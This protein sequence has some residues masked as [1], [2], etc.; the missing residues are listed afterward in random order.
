MDTNNDNRIIDY[1]ETWNLEAT[2]AIL[3]LLQPSNRKINNENI[4]NNITVAIFYMFFQ[5]RS[6]NKYDGFSNIK[7]KREFYF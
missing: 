2:K 7:N 4:K 3:Q 5:E 6:A 1:F